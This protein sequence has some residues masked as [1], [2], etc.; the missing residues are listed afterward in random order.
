MEIKEAARKDQKKVKMMLPD[1]SI[2]RKLS[3]LLDW[4]T[5]YPKAIGCLVLALS[6]CMAVCVITMSVG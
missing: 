6:I 3:L 4:G 1:L 5:R 2:S